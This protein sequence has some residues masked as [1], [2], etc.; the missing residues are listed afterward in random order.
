MRDYDQSLAKLQK[1]RNNIGVSLLCR[2]CALCVPL[3]L[4]H[5][6]HILRCCGSTLIVHG[7]SEVANV[8]ALHILDVQEG[9]IVLVGGCGARGKVITRTSPAHMAS[10]QGA[11]LHLAGKHSLLARR[12]TAT[13][14]DRCNHWGI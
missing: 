13:L 2:N 14:C 5:Q 10:F 6:Q 1:G 3:T 9:S 11:G 8:A 7:A 4:H 12:K